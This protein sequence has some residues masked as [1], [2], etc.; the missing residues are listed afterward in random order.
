MNLHLVVLAQKRHISTLTDK[1]FAYYTSIIFNAKG[2]QK[3]KH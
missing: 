1:T 3:L 2:E